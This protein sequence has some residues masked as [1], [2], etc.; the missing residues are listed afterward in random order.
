MR[1]TFY[2]NVFWATFEFDDFRVRINSLLN[3][4][5]CRKLTSYLCKKAK[6]SEISYKKTLQV[7]TVK[8]HSGQ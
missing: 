2:L 6:C 7:M 8:T 4:K 5:I 3:F 1:T